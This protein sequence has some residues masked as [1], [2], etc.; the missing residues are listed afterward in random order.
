[1]KI[2]K[3]AVYTLA[4]VMAGVFTAQ[5]QNTKQEKRAAKEAE[6]K[7]TI[8]AGSYTFT[9]Q[10]VNPLRGGTWQLNSAYYDLR[11]V[12]DTI[13][14]FLPFFGRAF[15]A[16]MNPDE[17]GIKFTSTKFTY[18]STLKKSGYEIVIKP[19]DT[20]DV[21]QM[22]LNVSLAGY[23]TLSVTNMNRDPISFY[24]TVEANKKTNL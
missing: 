17:S 5:A 1:M 18:T 9:A 10:Q 6:F 2:L 20:K 16:P 21:R 11:V 12:K 15:V 14:A 13:V 4:I 3:S 23:A 19:T 8:E 24:G 7:K 22:V